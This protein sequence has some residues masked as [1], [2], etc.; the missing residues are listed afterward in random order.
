M[1][2]LAEHL[3]VAQVIL[4]EFFLN[5]YYRERMSHDIDRVTIVV[6]REFERNWRLMVLI[7]LMYRVF[8]FQVR[9]N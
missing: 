6:L 9:E 1:R 2:H 3:Y 5:R 4:V 8:H 7:H